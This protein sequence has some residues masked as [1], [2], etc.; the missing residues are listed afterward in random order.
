MMGWH[1]ILSRDFLSIRHGSPVKERLLSK[2]R[3]CATIS[4]F[5]HSGIFDGRV[6]VTDALLRL[7]VRIW[8]CESG[9]VGVR[10][11]A[12]FRQFAETGCYHVV[13]AF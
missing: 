13:S 4:S 5:S 11:T 2:Q 9:K 3:I 12:I 6:A 1:H 7:E 8:Y 10:L